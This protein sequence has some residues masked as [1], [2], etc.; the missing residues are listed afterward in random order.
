MPSLPFCL[1]MD[2]FLILILS[3]ATSEKKEVCLHKLESHG[4]THRFRF[5][6]FLA[7]AVSQQQKEDRN[8]ETPVFYLYLKTSDVCD[9]RLQMQM[10]M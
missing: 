6:Y 4:L 8:A 7:D 9:S 1:S 5:V 3:S 2:L 10:Q